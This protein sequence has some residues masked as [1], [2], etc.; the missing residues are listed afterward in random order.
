MQG[1]GGRGGRL[2]YGIAVA[3]AAFFS[4]ALLNHFVVLVVDPLPL[5]TQQQPFKPGETDVL[6][7]MGLRFVPEDVEFVETR[8][9]WSTLLH[10]VL[11]V[12]L[13]DATMTKNNQLEQFETTPTD[14]LDARRH[15]PQLVYEET[16]FTLFTLDD[17]HF[18]P[19]NWNSEEQ[20]DRFT[21]Q[22][23]PHLEK[24][25]PN[26]TR[27][28]F[29]R[30]VLRTQSKKLAQ[31]PAINQ[32][33][34]DYFGDYD[35]FLKYQSTFDSNPKTGYRG[36][37]G[38]FDTDD[39]EVQIALRIWKP[40][41]MNTAVCDLPLAV[42]DASSLA[43]DNQADDRREYRYHVDFF[44]FFQASQLMTGLVARP[45]NRHRWF[46]YSF[47][48][49]SEIVVFNQFH[50]KAAKN[51]A[52]FHT[53]FVNPNCPR[54]SEPRSSIDICVNVMFPKEY[55]GT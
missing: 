17:H 36:I 45:H 48:N 38:E 7:Y 25:Y 55:S 5:Q 46:Y 51:F 4:N 24:L 21:K 54:D 47:M 2:V 28:V 41:Q 26:A 42:L 13:S 53:A 23:I 12:W 43:L 29:E 37:L 20:L 31:P 8:F 15:R 16:G 34:S 44:P 11:P 10:R 9:G 14:I 52:T 22:V 30:P 6:Q 49:T 27:F 18:E 32:V 19:T 1:S 35:K 40:I 39:D 33:H 50:K 3:V